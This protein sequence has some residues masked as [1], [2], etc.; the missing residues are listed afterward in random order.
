MV[1]VLKVCSFHIAV[2]TSISPPTV[3]VGDTVTFTCTSL[4]GPAMIQWE[5]I[6]NGDVVLETTS[7]MQMEL[8]LELGP[9]SQ[10]MNGRRCR[11]RVVIDGGTILETVTLTIESEP[12]KVPWPL[13]PQDFSCTVDKTIGRGR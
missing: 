8:A 3:T 4:L 10:S 12:T 1:T 2:E 6:G 9:V 7:G 5:D 13:Q 11:C